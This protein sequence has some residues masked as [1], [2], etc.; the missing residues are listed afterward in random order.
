M[1]SILNVDQI[2]NAAGTSAVT[3]DPS[4]GKPSFPN[5]AT[6]PAGSV[7]QVEKHNFYTKTQVSGTS[8]TTIFTG[9]A[10]TLS[11]TSS[12]VLISAYLAVGGFNGGT[13]KIQYTTDGGT[14]WNNITTADMGST[15]NGSGMGKAGLAGDDAPRAVFP[16]IV[17]R[18]RHQGVMVGMGQKDAYVGD[19]AQAKR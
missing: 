5:G 14:N 7:L 11:S 4:T 16:S 15:D 2:N 10:L 19:E 1:A 3:I 12:K 13:V 17:G 6:L 9:N 18:P 8:A